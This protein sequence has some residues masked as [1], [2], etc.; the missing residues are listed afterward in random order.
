MFASDV[1]LFVIALPDMILLQS[2]RP[3][4]MQRIYTFFKMLKFSKPLVVAI[5]VTVIS[6]TAGL[7]GYYYTPDAEGTDKQQKQ[8]QHIMHTLTQAEGAQGHK[9]VEYT[10]VA[11]NTTLEIAP[12]T[13]VQAWTYNGTIPG[14]TLRATEGDRVI[15]HFLNHTPMPHTVHLHGDHDEKNDGVFQ[16]VNPSGNYTYDFIAGPPGP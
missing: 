15:L 4:Y 8:Q 14:P 7:G 5:V 1:K 11:Q 9:T 2:K 3:P 6:T 16:I 13:R 10:L 12:H